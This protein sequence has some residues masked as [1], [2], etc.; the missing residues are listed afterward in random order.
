MSPRRFELEY[1]RYNGEPGNYWYEELAGLDVDQWY[2]IAVRA[3]YI[4]SGLSRFDCYL[5]KPGETVYLD[6]PVPLYGLSPT[7]RVGLEVDH[8]VASFDNVKVEDLGP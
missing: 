7:G 6:N 5:E 8:G 3:T 2:T 1:V 4:G